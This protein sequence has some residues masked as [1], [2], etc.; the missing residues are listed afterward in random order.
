MNIEEY[1]TAIG[2]RNTQISESQ[3]KHMMEWC[4][5]FI[6]FNRKKLETEGMT[7]TSIYE[8]YASSTKFPVGITSLSPCLYLFGLEKLRTRG[9]YRYVV[10]TK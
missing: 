2:I 9:V 5:K 8:M 1:K 3:L 7:A 10:Y 4:E 6:N